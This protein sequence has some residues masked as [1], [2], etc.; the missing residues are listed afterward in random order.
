ML[1]MNQNLT[2]KEDSILKRVVLSQDK[3]FKRNDIGFWYRIDHVGHG[4]GIKDS[5]KC[6]VSYKML[7]IGGKL[8]QSE[9]KQVVIGK[10]QL[11]TGLEEGLKLMNK[12]DSATFIVPWYLAYGMKG[13]DASIPAYTSII[14]RIKVFN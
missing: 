12:G 2:I 6:T 11:V 5:I 3:A 9:N 8:L 10:K 1:V 14:C 13:K 7:S 4:S